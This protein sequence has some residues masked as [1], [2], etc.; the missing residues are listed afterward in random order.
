MPL[1]HFAAAL[2]T[3]MRLALAPASAAPH[4]RGASRALPTRGSRDTHKSDDD[5]ATSGRAGDEGPCWPRLGTP[6]PRSPWRSALAACDGVGR[7]GDPEESG[8]CRRLCLWKDLAE[9]VQNTGRASTKISASWN[10]LEDRGEGKVP[11]L[12]RLGNLRE[13]PGHAARQS[14]RIPTYQEPRDPPR[15]SGLAPWHHLL[16]RMRTQDGRALQGR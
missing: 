11:V 3:T 1:I 9:A 7:D 6:S 14:R 15:W 12:Y 4:A 10:G 2:P 16:R 5:V 13:D 8:L